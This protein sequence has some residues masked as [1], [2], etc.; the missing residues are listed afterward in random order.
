MYSYSFDN[1]P[2][3]DTSGFWLYDYF[4]DSANRLSS[5]T[6]YY[7]KQ[8][9]KNNPQW[10]KQDYIQYKY[11]SGNSY[12]LTLEGRYSKT[13]TRYDKHGHYEYIKTSHYDTVTKSWRT[14]ALSTF[15]HDTA[16]LITCRTIYSTL[17]NDIPGR[18]LWTYSNKGKNIEKLN[19]EKSNGVWENTEKYDSFPGADGNDTTGKYYTWKN[20][21]WRLINA[22]SY[23]YTTKGQRLTAV[24]TNYDT[25][26]PGDPATVGFRDSFTYY[27]DGYLMIHYVSS[28]E[29][30]SKSWF[31]LYSD[32]FAYFP[33][34]HLLSDANIAYNNDKPVPGTLDIIY[35]NEDGSVRQQKNHSIR[36]TFY[37]DGKLKTSIETNVN[38]TTITEYYYGTYPYTSIVQAGDIRS[39]YRIFPNPVTEK[40][41]ISIGAA[42]N[43]P[44]KITLYSYTGQRLLFQTIH[45][46]EYSLDVTPYKPGIYLLIITCDK[47]E[48]RIKVLK[49]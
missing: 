48:E 42:G 43:L 36:E 1:S 35:Y 29:K 12:V 44:A 34:H 7:A 14:A 41:H 26:R 23:T 40:L 46:P 47:Y 27:S 28:Y 24:T 2:G 20:G 6:Y 37:T 9:I 38:N 45:E 21:Q 13:E 5:Q 33:D 31:L 32:S 19:Q 3:S 15:Q 4:Y 30:I 18:T 39:G 49:E 16:G 22:T 8:K 17:S 10:I 11:D 25:T